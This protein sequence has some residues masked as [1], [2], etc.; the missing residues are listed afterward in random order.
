MNRA[1]LPYLPE[2]IQTMSIQFIDL[3]AQQARLRGKLDAAI[4]RV[5][6]EGQYIM[7]PEVASFEKQ[8]RRVLRRQALS[9]APTAPTRSS[10]H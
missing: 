5:L 6:D 8:P 4:A 3:A 7:G 2:H 9:A 1:V 10:S